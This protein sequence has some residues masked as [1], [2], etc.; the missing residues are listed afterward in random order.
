MEVQLNDTI[1]IPRTPAEALMKL[2]HRVLDMT[3]ETGPGNLERAEVIIANNQR[4]NLK[5][6]VFQTEKAIYEDDIKPMT[7]DRMSRNAERIRGWEDAFSE[8][9]AN[10]IEGRR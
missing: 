3:D 1:T 7:V 2:A 8:D 6:A 10:F 4:N 9:K 5:E